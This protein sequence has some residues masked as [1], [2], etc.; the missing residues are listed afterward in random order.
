MEIAGIITN[1]PE[2][3]SE[4]L[5][6]LD[7]RKQHLFLFSKATHASAVRFMPR[8]IRLKHGTRDEN[9]VNSVVVSAVQA[10]RV[11][12]SNCYLVIVGY[13]VPLGSRSISNANQ[14]R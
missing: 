10:S 9:Q 8:E 13:A 1:C 5:V 12:L 6:H 7:L 2:I 4:I 14:Y 3:M 11:V